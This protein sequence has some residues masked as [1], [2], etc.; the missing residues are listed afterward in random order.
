MA[1]QQKCGPYVAGS[2]AAYQLHR[3]KKER[4]CEVC[5]AAYLPV[6]ERKPARR[7]ARTTVAMAPN[8]VRVHHPTL[9]AGMEAYRAM[10]AELGRVRDERLFRK[11]HV[12]FNEWV[13]ELLGLSPA[14]AFWMIKHGEEE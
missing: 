12:T 11:T 4:P 6:S 3:R 2:Y 8:P 14:E 9:T 7:T 13:D 5:A 10:G 1:R